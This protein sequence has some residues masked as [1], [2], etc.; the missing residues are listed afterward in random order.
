M[1][2][3]EGSFRKGRSNVKTLELGNADPF[4]RG[5]HRACY[6]H[7][8]DQDLCVKVMIEDWREADRRKRAHW[9]VRLCRPKWYFHENLLEFR[10]Y[11]RV[12]KRVGEAAREFMPKCYEM[13][14]TDHGEGMVVDLICDHDGRVSQTLADYL[15]HQGLTRECEEALDYFWE[16]LEKY[17]IFN[18]GR[19]DNVVVRQKADGGI[20]LVAIDG[21]GLS[22]LV[23]I[24]EWISSRAKARLERW[25][26][27][28]K[29]A[30]SRAIELRA[31]GKRLTDKG[32]TR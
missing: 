27:K 22:Q 12:E 18:R 25:R 14:M 15:F 26:E 29:R 28:Q 13:V 5:T 3:S 10:F 21:F 8:G 20:A 31:A 1:G 30:I 7:P 23:P 9:L 24:A 17:R 11:H 32:V 19:P 6:R 16:G 2:W 4:G